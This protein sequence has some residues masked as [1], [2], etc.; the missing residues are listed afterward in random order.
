LPPAERDTPL[1]GPF[2][3]PSRTRYHAVTKGEYPFG[4]PLIARPRV[5][6][7]PGFVSS[8]S[9]RGPGSPWRLRAAWGLPCFGSAPPKRVPRSAATV[10][11]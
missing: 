8:T 5:Q 11:A 10:I 6:Y 9:Y 2:A 4:R 7:H 1:A 3:E